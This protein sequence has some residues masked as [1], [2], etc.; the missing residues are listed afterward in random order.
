MRLIGLA[1]DL[2]LNRV[3]ALPVAGAQSTLSSSCQA[4]LRQ[5]SLILKV[6][7]SIGALLVGASEVRAM[8]VTVDGYAVILSGPVVSDDLVKVQNVFAQ[9]PEISFAILRNSLGGHAPT[10]YRVGELF[11]DK[12]ITTAVSGHCISSCSRMFLGGRQRLFTDD[13][14]PAQTFVGFHGHYDLAGRLDIQ[15]VRANDLYRWIVKYSDGKAD[16]ALVQ[17]WIN[18]E[19]A[20]GAANFLHPD[21]A[22]GRGASVFICSGSEQN[23]PL[24]CEPL[25]TNA[26]DR[27]VITDLRRLSSPDQARLPHRL[28]AQMHP[29]SGYA[30]IDDLGKVPL[31]S[32]DGIDNYKRFLDSRVPRAFAVSAT[33][34]HWAWNVGTDA[35]EVALRRCAERA[36][37]ACT[38]YAVDESVVY[39]P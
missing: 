24:G 27:G 19:N 20:R 39:K 31:D 10:G 2:G 35:S 13:Y 17:R 28:R 26:L 21:V 33:G 25:A 5:V 12:G 8:E 3:L 37:Q 36:G 30:E 18:I 4:V 9:H 11:R 14:P 7:F 38:L 1:V 34:R 16:K 29:P 6:G 15:S 23:R 32:A 22:T